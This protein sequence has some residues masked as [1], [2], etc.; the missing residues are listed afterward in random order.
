MNNKVSIIV[1]VYNIEKYVAKC[2]ESIINQEY[3]NIEIILVNDG[4]KDSSLEICEKYKKTDR[5]IIVIDKKN[6]GVSSAR[7]AGLDVASGDYIVF[8]DGDDYLKPDFITYMLGLINDNDCDFGLSKNCYKYENEEQVSEDKVVVMDK[9]DATVLLLSPRVDV[10]CWNKIYR[11]SFIKNLRFDENQFFGEG[12][13]FITKVS[14]L[15][16]HTAVGERK[17]YHYRQDN[18]LSATKKFK[19]KNFINGEKSLQLIENNLIVNDSR[20]LDQLYSHYCLFY[21]YGLT[22]TLKNNARKENKLTYVDWEKKAKK[23]Y[24]YLYKN[25]WVGFSLKMKV[26]ILLYLPFVYKIRYMLFK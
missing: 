22:A 8:V 25:T 4:S 2:I 13:Q 6:G 3:K 14:Q 23:M 26:F 11:K 16:T 1:P 18:N 12:L 20:I 15:S 7:N 5:R 10:G 21:F 19:F 9:V 24:K 17:V